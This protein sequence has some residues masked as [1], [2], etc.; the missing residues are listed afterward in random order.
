MDKLCGHR[1]LMFDA[2]NF[3]TVMGSFAS[4]RLHMKLGGPPTAYHPEGDLDPEDIATWVHEATHFHQT[5]FTAFGQI[6]WELFRQVT[7]AAWNEWMKLPAKP[8][9]RR[10]VPLAH[11]GFDQA[12]RA[13]SFF[14]QKVAFELLD[15]LR[16][17]H[18]SPQSGN[19]VS[20]LGMMMLKEPWLANPTITLEGNDHVLRGEDVMEGHAKFI[21]ATFLESAGAA[22]EGIWNHDRISPTYWLARDWFLS[23]IGEERYGDFPFVC[24]LA[25]QTSISDTDASADARE[26]LLQCFPS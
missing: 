10:G 2:S 15:L 19:K 16:G 11:A 8:H 17:W 25:M 21:E 3:K 12:T 13:N 20:D 23:I 14:S 7:S 1:R 18:R 9:G 5:L 22:R 26:W 24:D 6:T 4:F